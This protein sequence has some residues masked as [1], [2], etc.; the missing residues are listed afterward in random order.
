[1]RFF[2][3]IITL[4][5]FCTNSRAIDPI[6]EISFGIHY[7]SLKEHQGV[8]FYRDFQLDP[9]L[10]F[11]IFN[12]NFEF[13]GDSLNYS[14]FLVSDKVKLRSKIVEIS[15]RPFFPNNKSISSAGAHRKNSLEWVNRIELN[16]PNYSTTYLGQI[17]FEIDHDL[18]THHGYYFLFESKIKL[19]KYQMIEP[20][21][22]MSMGLGD[23]KNNTY[24]F[25]PSAKDMSINNFEIGI[26]ILVPEEVDRYYSL[27]QIHY[28]E[29]INDKNKNA[30]YA[31]KN[32]HGLQ[33]TFTIVK[34]IY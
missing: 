23:L 21:F 33:L 31:K 34:N 1:M 14:R 32:N 12:D 22:F 27:A 28:F 18:F 3:F 9:D 30:E 8:I 24:Y 4:L 11:K 2:S 7:Q 19:F 17:A 26:N 13:V 16:Y 25:G 20:D 6:Y 5:V 15:D 29:V 10:N